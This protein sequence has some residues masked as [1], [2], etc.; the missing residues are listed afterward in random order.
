[1]FILIEILILLFGLVI[2]FGLLYIML[3]GAPYAVT[4]SERIET[5]MD[6]L[7]IHKGERAIDLGSGDGR[8]VMAL[9]EAG[10]K[11]EGY[12]INPVLVWLSRRTIRRAGLEHSARV[13]WKS[14]WHAD[15][16][17]YDI[18]TIFGSPHIMGAVE[19]KLQKE[20]RP[21]ARVGSVSFKFPHWKIA[22]EKERVLIYRR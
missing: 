19:K 17:Q 20:L 18:V 10:A 15:F 9:A 13:Y 7:N 8:I 3:R 16:S 12:E 14:F 2:L 5:L 6:L 1:V 11:S 22:K 4:A 21:G